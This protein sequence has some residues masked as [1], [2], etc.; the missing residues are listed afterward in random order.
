[1]TLCALLCVPVYA[2]ICI[3]DRITPCGYRRA[4]YP[5]VYYMIAGKAV[6]LLVFLLPRDRRMPWAKSCSIWWLQ[7][8]V[9][10]TAPH[11]NTVCHCYFYNWTWTLACCIEMITRRPTHQKLD[12]SWRWCA[13]WFSVFQKWKWSL[14]RCLYDAVSHTSQVTL[15]VYQ[16]PPHQDKIWKRSLICIGCWCSDSHSV[17]HLVQSSQ[18]HLLH[19]LM[20]PF[21]LRGWKWSD[22]SLDGMGYIACICIKTT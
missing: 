15:T 18:L 9:H 17:W 21:W 4:V 19:L 12:K 6:F 14:V 2:Y 20:L 8:A 10:P 3:L 22:Y 7:G 13:Q 5:Y 11:V 1:M 16:F